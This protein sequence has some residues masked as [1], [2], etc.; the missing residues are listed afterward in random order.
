MTFFR[1]WE[2]PNLKSYIFQII[3]SREKERERVKQI[4]KEAHDSS[5]GHFRVNKILDRIRK[6]FYWAI[7]KGIEGRYDRI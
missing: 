2:T 6:R 3:V 7:C 5:L 1:K 4:L